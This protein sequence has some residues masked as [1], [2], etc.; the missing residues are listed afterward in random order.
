MLY[1]H[2]RSLQY[3]IISISQRLNTYNLF[4]LNPDNIYHN[5]LL[6]LYIFFTFLTI[7]ILLPEIN[8]TSTSS[9]F[10]VD[11]VITTPINIFLL[12]SSLS[13]L[14]T[15]SSL[16]RPWLFSW[17]VL[18]PPWHGS[19]TCNKSVRFVN[20]V[21]L[22]IIVHSLPWSCSPPFSLVYA[23]LFIFVVFFFVYVFIF[24]FLLSFVFYSRDFFFFSFVRLSFYLLYVLF[25]LF[26]PYFFFRDVLF[27]L[28]YTALSIFFLSRYIFV[29]LI[30]SFIFLMLS[31][32]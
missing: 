7:I 3:H 18:L 21:L 16:Y 9:T 32:L 31:I 20:R 2:R 11:P 17:F 25:L 6:S 5:F 23:Y 13:H 30:Y 26:C 12:L 19:N 15:A 10:P 4:N 8:I 24:C 28:L 1:H 27:L 29:L 22:H 14:I